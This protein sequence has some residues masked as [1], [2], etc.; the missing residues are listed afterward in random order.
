MTPK[1]EARRIMAHQLRIRKAARKRFRKAA[2]LLAKERK[3]YE[4][5]HRSWY[6]E[7]D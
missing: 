3:A 1:A 6:R 5:Q 4:K 2:L 7:D